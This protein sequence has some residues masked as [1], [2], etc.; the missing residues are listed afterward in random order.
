MR[1]G[2]LKSRAY[3]REVGGGAGWRVHRGSGVSGVRLCAAHRG[4]VCVRREH[5]VRQVRRRGEGGRVRGDR[6]GRGRQH[7]R[8]A[9]RVLWGRGEGRRQTEGL[10][11]HT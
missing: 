10:L 11:G 9:D 2:Q 4:H 7:R 8:H 3:V 6:V 1:V 5:V